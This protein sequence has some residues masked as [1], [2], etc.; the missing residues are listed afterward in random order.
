MARFRHTILLEPIPRAWFEQAVGLCFD[1]LVDYF[2]ELGDPPGPDTQYEL[3]N[4]ATT[5]YLE[6]WQRDGVTEGRS[7]TK[8]DGTVTITTFRLDSPAN[9]RTA[10]LDGDSRDLGRGTGWL[11]AMAGSL[12]LDLPTWWAGT[13]RKGAA[14]AVTANAK[15][16]MAHVAGT[17][18]PAPGA[19]GRWQV[20]V[21]V[22]LRG[23]GLLRPL[24]APVVLFT[25]AKIARA[26]RTAVD[27]FAHRWNDEVP[28][29]LTR[30]PDELRELIIAEVERPS[31]TTDA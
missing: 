29:L 22:T 13:E 31:S 20:T 4:E 1:T 28:Q 17:I 9:P 27:E 7:Y 8:A 25:R 12:R 18:T 5:V 30:Q 26:F 23:R 3:D 2:T 14:P 21:E 16:A 15:H 6:S 24:V 11:S 19:G 10:V